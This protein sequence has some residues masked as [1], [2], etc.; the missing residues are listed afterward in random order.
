MDSLLFE[1]LLENFY[2]T[3]SSLTYPKSQNRPHWYLGIYLYRKHKCKVRRA[4]RTIV[5]DA[6]THFHMIPVFDFY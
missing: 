4:S 1:E 3:Y 2:M 6:A 5:G